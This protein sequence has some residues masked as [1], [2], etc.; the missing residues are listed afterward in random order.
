M[1]QTP[2]ND[3]LKERFKK[4]EAIKGLG[5]EPFGGRFDK[6]LSI[7]ELVKSFSEDKRVVRTAGR[8]WA[9]RLM[10][11]TAFCDLKDESGRIQLYVKPADLSESEAKLFGYLDIGDIVGVEGEFFKTKTGETSIHARKLTLLAKSLRPMPSTWHGLKDVETRYRQRYLDLISND[12][13]KDL[14]RKRSL[15]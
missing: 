9:I 12:E 6:E 1:E 14:F 8:L 10:G 11:K 3:I 7:A 2:F 4:F 5:I 13:V 15:L